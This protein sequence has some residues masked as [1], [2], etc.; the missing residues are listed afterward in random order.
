MS[1]I[2]VKCG[3]CGYKFDIEDS[4]KAD[5]ECPI[6]YSKYFEYDEDLEKFDDYYLRSNNDDHEGYYIQ[7]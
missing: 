2:W 5:F 6:C 3:S 4:I 7:H 1:A